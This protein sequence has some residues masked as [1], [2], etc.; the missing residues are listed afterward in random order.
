MVSDAT[1]KARTAAVL[2]R[3]SAYLPQWMSVADVVDEIADPAEI[4]S[5]E[6]AIRRT[7]ADRVSPVIFTPNRCAGVLTQL[8]SM[9]PAAR[10]CRS[11]V[12]T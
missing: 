10:R 6:S 12:G 8:M 4:G 11:N 7:A 1:Y 5:A 9:V 3:E 2:Y